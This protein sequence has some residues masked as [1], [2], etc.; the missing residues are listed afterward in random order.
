MAPGGLIGDVAVVASQIVSEGMGTDPTAGYT[1][2]VLGAVGSPLL[3]MGLAVP[4]WT[5]LP[6][7]PGHLAQLGGI[8]GTRGQGRD[9]VWVNV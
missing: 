7:S 6:A 3:L 4:G 1:G 2:R 8:W 9:H 5:E